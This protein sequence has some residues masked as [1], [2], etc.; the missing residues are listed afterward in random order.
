MYFTLTI[1]EI[2]KVVWLIEWEIHVGGVLHHSSPPCTKRL[3]HISP[4]AP[5]ASPLLSVHNLMAAVTAQ[6]IHDGP[7]SSI[8]ITSFSD[9]FDIHVR[10][11]S[12]APSPFSPFFCQMMGNIVKWKDYSGGSFLISSNLVLRELLLRAYKEHDRKAFKDHEVHRHSCDFTFHI[13][14]LTK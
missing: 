4:E 5:A 6:L 9:S 2:L 11:Y 8:P 1:I 12:Y 13:S 10:L 3:W 14:N 7:L